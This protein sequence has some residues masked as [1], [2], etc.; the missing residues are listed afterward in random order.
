[1]LPIILHHIYSEKIILKTQNSSSLNSLP[2]LAYKLKMQFYTF[3]VVAAQNWLVTPL[4]YS[5]LA[6]LK[7]SRYTHAHTH[8]LSDE[9]EEEDENKNHHCFYYYSTKQ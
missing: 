3:I 6:L 7:L 1:M 4:S 8:T 2:L 5:V 9:E